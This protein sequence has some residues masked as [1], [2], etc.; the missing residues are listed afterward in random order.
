VTKRRVHHVHRLR[1]VG[2]HRFIKGSNG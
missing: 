2:V 1:R